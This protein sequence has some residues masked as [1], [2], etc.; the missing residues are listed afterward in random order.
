[1]TTRSK[2]QFY[3]TIVRTVLTKSAYTLI[4]DRIRRETKREKLQI[5]FSRVKYRSRRDRVDRKEIV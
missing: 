2:V 4:R 3:K 5:R 1:M